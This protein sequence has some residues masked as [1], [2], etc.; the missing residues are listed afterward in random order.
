MLMSRKTVSGNLVQLS[1]SSA[2]EQMSNIKI[3]NILGQAMISKW[4]KLT[5]GLNNIYI[6]VEEL[7]K[8][9]YRVIV[10]VEEGLIKDDFF[11]ID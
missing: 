3:L 6:N 10:N 5:P 1:L 8:G 4:E 11:I 7:N 2:E 9:T